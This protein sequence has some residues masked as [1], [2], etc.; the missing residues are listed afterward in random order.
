MTKIKVE[1]EIRCTSL[2]TIWIISKNIVWLFKKIQDNFFLKKKQS[3]SNI[4]NRSELP[5]Q[6]CNQDHELY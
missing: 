3:N 6:T 2:K 4:L 1:R 5:R